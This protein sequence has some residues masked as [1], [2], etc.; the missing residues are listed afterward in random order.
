MILLAIR[1]K[2]APLV[3]AEPDTLRKRPALLA[4]LSRRTLN[5]ALAQYQRG[6]GE[7]VISSKFGDRALQ[8]LQRPRCDEGSS[9]V[10]NFPQFRPNSRVGEKLS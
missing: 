2:A 3:V 9:P 4:L 7:P 10:R 6:K 8:F 5:L 1:T